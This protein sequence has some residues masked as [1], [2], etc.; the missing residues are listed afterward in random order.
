MIA[1]AEAAGAAPPSF[2]YE[3]ED[4]EPHALVNMVEENN[5]DDFGF[6]IFRTYFGDDQLW[7]GFRELWDALLQ[8]G[9][10]VAPASQGLDRIRDR[11]LMKIVDDEMTDGAKAEDVASAYRLFTEDEDGLDEDEKL[12]PGLKTKM[13]LF[14]DEQ[15]MRSVT[16][17]STGTPPF[18]KAVDVELGSTTN[19][20]PGA[21]FKVAIKDVATHFYP[22][23]W[24][25]D[26]ADVADFRPLKEDHVWNR[27][28]LSVYGST[29]QG[30]LHRAIVT[31]R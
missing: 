2:V 7:E 12:E 6:L 25:P 15:C 3:V 21:V 19:Q 18:V 24:L 11:L 20:R 28:S 23:L 1:K 22:A 26:I 31:E 14:V 16:T 17:P 9:F 10:D 30:K 8:H 13:C 27:L 5:W 4:V 29:Q